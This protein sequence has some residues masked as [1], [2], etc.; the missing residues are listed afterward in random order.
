[1]PVRKEIK[2]AEEEKYWT[3]VFHALGQGI[4]KSY[5]DISNDYWGKNK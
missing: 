1:M 3:R 2:N 5:R 4:D